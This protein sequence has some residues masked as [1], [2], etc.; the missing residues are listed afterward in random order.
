MLNFQKIELMLKHLVANG[1]MSGYMS[2]LKENQ[3]RRV[4]AVH[5][6]MMGNLVG[7]LVENTFSELDDSPQSTNELKEPSF[8]FSFTVNADA[9]FY[10]NKK[11]AL[12]LLIDDRNDLIHHLLPRTN[13]L[14]I[15]G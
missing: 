11:Q 1:R 13:R 9:D 10:E 8:S 15:C 6:Q 7:Q 2:E 12:K 14:L 3:E 4:A 5:K